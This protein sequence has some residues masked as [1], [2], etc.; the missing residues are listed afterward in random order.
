MRSPGRGRTNRPTL[1]EIGVD[2]AAL[3]GVFF[4]RD[5]VSP[6]ENMIA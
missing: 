6:S 3:D 2:Q 5:L 1:D 4:G